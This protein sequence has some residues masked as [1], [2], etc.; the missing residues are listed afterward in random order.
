MKS[1]SV[2]YQNL[3]MGEAA[4]QKHLLYLLWRGK[5]RERGRLKPSKGEPV[6]MKDE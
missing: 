2:S 1:S 5:G 4:K 3:E 6:N